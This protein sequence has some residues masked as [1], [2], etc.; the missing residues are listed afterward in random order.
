MIYIVQAVKNR[1]LH[2]NYDD[3]QAYKPSTARSD[4]SDD[5]EIF[6]LQDFDIKRLRDLVLKANLRIPKSKIYK[7]SLN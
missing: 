4:G 5:L 6:R 3:N 2:K 1:K 7:S